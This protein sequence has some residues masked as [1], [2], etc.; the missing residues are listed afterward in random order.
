MGIFAPG[1]KKIGDY[2]ENMNH[3][4][5]AH[6]EEFGY[7]GGS[8]WQAQER[9]ANNEIMNVMYFKTTEGLHDFAHHDIHRQG[10]NWWNKNIKDMPHISIWH[11]VYSVPKGR[12]ES[13]F[14]N[15]HPDVIGELIF[16]LLLLLL[17]IVH[18]LSCPR[19]GNTS[20]ISTD[21]VGTAATTFRIDHP[22]AKAE[23]I[24]PGKPFYVSPIVDARRGLL[25]TSA[26]RLSASKSKGKEHDAYNDDPYENYGKLGYVQ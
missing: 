15:S 23:G 16:L 22:D 9:T 12:W 4:L 5:E 11:E 1:V 26:G 17:L 10:W 20:T 2:F 21:F 24:E 3:Y 19:T 7:L 6:A 14:V 13:I 8:N 25:K 18:V